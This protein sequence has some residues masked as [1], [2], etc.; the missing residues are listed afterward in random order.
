[1]DTVEQKRKR[2]WRLEVIGAVIVCV[3]APLLHFVYEWSGDNFFVGLFAATNES[4]WEHTKLIYF[5]MLVWAVIE[6]FIL[7]PDFKRFLAAKAVALAFCS[8][9][10]IAFF[11]TYTGALGFESLI[12]DIICTFVW[13]ALG[14]VISYKLYH[15]HYRLRRYF[16]LFCMLFAGQ[17]AVQ[18]LF[19][20]FAPN[21]PLFEDHGS[22]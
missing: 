18:I 20:P 8:L 16:P 4:V 3:C 12:L 1:M 21:L 7:K 14:F 6:Y 13:T 5:P 22:A 11:Y 10:T 9:V 17:L 19:T 15:S 2:Y